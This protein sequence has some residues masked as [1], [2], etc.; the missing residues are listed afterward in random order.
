[1]RKAVYARLA[2]T[3][4]RKN[5]QFYL[6]YL[7]ASSLCVMMFYVVLA[8]SADPE[9]GFQGEVTGAIMTE[10]GYIAAVF[11]AF[12]LFYTSGFVNRSRQKEFGV[13]N[14]LGME[15]RHIGRMLV[16]ETLYTSAASFV[17]G[18]GGGIVLGELLFLLLLRLTDLPVDTQY[19]TPSAYAARETVV[20]YGL[21]FLLILARNL[22]RLFR[23]SGTGLLQGG[24]MGEKKPRTKWFKL[25]AGLV[26]L[27]IGYG[28]ALMA[29]STVAIF[30][31]F[32]VAVVFVI[33]GTYLLFEAGSIA[34][35]KALRKNKNYYYHPRHFT[36]VSGMIWR[37]KQNAAGLAS[38][39][40][41]STAVL[42]TIS[43]TVCLYAGWEDTLN[44]SM[45]RHFAV[46]IYDYDGLGTETAQ[47]V[48]GDGGAAADAF[49][50]RMEQE[51]GVAFEGL[52][53]T[54]ESRSHGRT[55]YVYRF[56]TPSLDNDQ[57]LELAGQLKA[58]LDGTGWNLRFHSKAES[59]QDFLMLYG[60][61]LFAGIF[62]GLIFLMAT[63]VIIYYK[64]VSEGYEDKERFAILQKVGMS[65]Q[66]VRRTINSQVLTVFFLPLV[67]AAV[68]LFMALRPLYI[69]LSESFNIQN[70]GL[71]ALVTGVTLLLFAAVYVVVYLL[72]AK[73]YYKIVA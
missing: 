50:A 67:A 21:I 10:A 22:W 49:I 64:Q 70:F 71:F 55:I 25:A 8:I 46:D 58:Q 28:I 48:T 65:R 63:A 17:L 36:G 59:R 68:H 57:Q 34:L 12:F 20:V 54:A 14:I 9:F 30:M 45:P 26:S 44:G 13:Y 42:V 73:V 7:L 37:M 1:M 16:Y 31:W 60:S 6:P 19:L 52:T 32:L 11:S 66:E 33:I 41:L 53:R 47:P 61:L 69:V 23:T 39:C 56:D 24:R 3:S 62:F 15:R 43:T 4:V 38:I 72:T 18:I 5:K 51:S 29:E 27:G 35:L 2:L 40:I